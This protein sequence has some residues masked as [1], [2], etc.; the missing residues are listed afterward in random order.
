MYPG[1][2]GIKPAF[3]TRFFLAKLPGS[4]QTTGV[5]VFVRRFLPALLGLCVCGCRSGFTPLPPKETRSYQS[6]LE[7]SPANGMP[8]AILLVQTPKTNFL[9]CVGLADLKRKVPLRSDHA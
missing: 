7:W 4:G 9:G 2:G 1:R 3:E 6:L 5:K 8:G